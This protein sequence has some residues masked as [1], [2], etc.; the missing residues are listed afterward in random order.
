MASESFVW[1][2]QRRVVS[3]FRVMEHIDLRLRGRA[4][5]SPA[6]RQAPRRGRD[7]VG[8][9]PSRRA[10]SLESQARSHASGSI[11]FEAPP[12]RLETGGRSCVKNRQEVR[13]Q[14]EEQAS[15]VTVKAR[16]RDVWPWAG[17]WLN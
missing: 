12:G 6:G 4:L 5:S 2:A 14:Q 1:T 10:A 3:G 7:N 9:C 11:R 15:E 13:T 16:T 8:S 17:Q